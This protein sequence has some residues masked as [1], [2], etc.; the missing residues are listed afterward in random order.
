MNIQISVIVPVYNVQRFISSC[1]ESILCQRNATFEVICVNDGST[2]DSR[3]KVEE[4]AKRDKR[5]ILID[6]PNQGLSCARNTGIAKARGEWLCFV[7]SDDKIG[8][9]GKTS[10]REFRDLLDFASDDVDA[11]VGNA[12]YLDEGNHVISGDWYVNRRLG[13]FVPTP[14]TLRYCNVTAWG[15]LYRRSLVVENN[16]RFP[17]GLRYEDQ[18]FFPKFFA[19]TRRFV[20]TAVPFCSYYKHENTIMDKTRRNKNISNGRDYL[21]IIDSNLAFFNERKLTKKFLPY[22][23]QQ[24]FELLNDAIDLS[25]PE[26]KQTLINEFQAILAKHGLPLAGNANLRNLGRLEQVKSSTLKLPFKEAKHF[27]PNLFQCFSDGVRAAASVQHRTTLSRLLNIGINAYG[28]HVWRQYVRSAKPIVEGDRLD[29]IFVPEQGFINAL[30]TADVVSFDIFDTLLIRK[31]LEPIDVFKLMEAEE[32]E[33]GFAEARVYAERRARASLDKADVTLEDI[34]AFIPHRFR[35][36][37]D[38]ERD[39]E[40]RMLVRNP[41]AWELYQ[42]ALK[43][44]KRII[45]VSDMYL[46]EAFLKQI[47]EAQGFDRLEHVFVSNAMNATKWTGKLFHAAA[48]QLQVKPQLF[49]HVGDNQHSDVEKAKDSGWQAFWL[50]QIRMQI[51]SSRKKYAAADSSIAA[52]IHN[53]LI[54]RYSD[55]GDIWNEYG[56]A[57]GGPLVLSFLMWIIRRAKLSGVDHLAFV[58]RDGWILKEM[59]EKHLRS[60]GLGA[61]Y[62]YL[63]RTISLLSTL[64]HNGAPYYV[65]YILEKAKEEGVRISVARTL[66]GNLAIYRKNINE[67]REWAAPRRKELE[68]HLAERIGD[69]RSPAFVDLTSMWLSSLSA[70]REIIG[71]RNADNFVL[72]FFGNLCETKFGDLPFEAAIDNETG[73]SVTHWNAQL[74]EEINIVNIIESIVS[75]PEKRVVGLKNGNPVFGPDGAKLYYDAVSKGIDEYITSF[76]SDFPADEKTVL[77][78]EEAVGIF[79]QFAVEMGERDRYIL[80]T[81]KHSAHIENKE[82]AAPLA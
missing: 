12:S 40:K 71:S 73:I 74:A 51:D 10:G 18:G 64:T 44:G 4:Y 22:L 21:G 23:Q 69:A 57:L 81:V 80:S 60:A 58:G 52:S 1:L 20:L 56:Y 38:K 17:D 19:L 65:E 45:A 67:L 33:E 49:L 13:V 14:E 6:Q 5:I 70:G 76:L 43:A 78:I 53:S 50:P 35:R 8:W 39:A 34:Y 46:D 54:C 82:E 26:D 75:S 24:S 41:I 37:L 61:S 29:R 47:L 62:V 31:V 27:N 16:L 11:V 63:P 3:A 15:K 79:R 7:D 2:D 48:A 66:E 55:R 72:W 9:N 28:Q 36:L 77:P 30:Q 32:G 42:A 59:Y 68:R 25:A